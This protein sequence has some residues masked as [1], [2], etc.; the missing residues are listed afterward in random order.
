VRRVPI[1]ALAVGVLLLISGALEWLGYAQ[2]LAALCGLSE[3]ATRKLGMASLALGFLVIGIPMLISQ[4][5]IWPER[6]PNQ[7]CA[8]IM[9][10]NRRAFVRLKVTQRMIGLSDW[11]PVQPRFE[12]PNTT[13]AQRQ[14]D[15][16]DE[17]RD[18]IW[19]LPQYEE[20]AICLA[21]RGAK[22]ESVNFYASYGARPFA[23]PPSLVPVVLH[24]EC[25][26]SSAKI[27]ERVFVIE[28]GP[29]NIVRVRRATRYEAD[30]TR[31][32]RDIRG[33]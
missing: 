28:V 16:M 20:V 9:V 22:A 17:L 5:K 13:Q 3:C 6:N 23:N 24:L 25:L 1:R 27:L 30:L 11:S 18:G 19:E 21:E 29:M 12:K 33:V 10:R 2:S 15:S 8:R 31:R 4:L 32:G 26:G 7:D 14:S